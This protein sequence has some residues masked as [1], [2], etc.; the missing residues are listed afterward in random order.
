MKTAFAIHRVSV[1]FLAK[2]AVAL[3]L[4]WRPSY[5]AHVLADFSASALAYARKWHA[6]LASRLRWL[7]VEGYVMHFLLQY[8]LEQFLFAPLCT[9]NSNP[10]RDSIQLYAAK[11]DS[12]KVNSIQSNCLL[13][14]LWGV[15]VGPCSTSANLAAQ[16]SIMPIVP[17]L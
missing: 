10:L 15:G 2:W 12:I 9:Q 13:D 16:C 6:S 1:R 8:E 11:F 4:P 17:S 7:P 3:Q 14:Y 5:P